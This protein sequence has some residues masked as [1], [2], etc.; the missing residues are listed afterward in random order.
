MKISEFCISRPVFTT[1]L[2]TAMLVF[3][4]TSYS[5][6]GVSLFPDVDFP[7]V[8]VTVV[9]EGADPETVE[10]EVTDVIEESVNTISGI[11]SLRSESAEGI[12]Q[13]FIEFEMLSSRRFT[14][15][16]VETPIIAVAAG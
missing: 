16:Y 8:T 6:I 15:L 11:K 12:A 13:V 7:I 5:S 9:Y 3:G 1:M 14:Y 2:V 4:L 10:T